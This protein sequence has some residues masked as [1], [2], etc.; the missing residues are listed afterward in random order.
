MDNREFKQGLKMLLKID[1]MLKCK[2][3]KNQV[4]RFS[5]SSINQVMCVIGLIALT[6]TGC[7][8]QAMK[9]PVSSPKAIKLNQVGYYP[10]APKKLVVS[11]SATYESFSIVDRNSN[12]TVFTADLSPQTYRELSG[13][14]VQVGDFTAF[15]K[16]GEY[17]VHIEG[18]GSSYPFEIADHVLLE[19][20]KAS[21]KGLYYQRASMDLEQQYAGNWHRKMGHPDENVRFHP[22]SGSEGELSSPGGWYDAGD[23]GKYV[24]N[25]AFSLGQ[26]LLLYEQYSRTLDNLRLNIPESN[27]EVSDYLDEIKYEMDWLLTMQDADGGVFFKLT[28]KNFE[29]M[30]MPEEAVS[31]RY[32]IGKSTT[33]TLDFAAAAAKCYTNFHK[34]DISYAQRCLAAAVRAW[35]WARQNPEVAYR[36]PEDIS[37]GQYGDR[38]FEQEFYWAAAELYIATGDQQYLSYLT[39]NSPKLSFGPG[40][41]WNGFMEFLGAFALIDRI[42]NVH[43]VDPLKVM[44]LELADELADRFLKGVQWSEEQ[45]K[46][47]EDPYYGGAGYGNN[48][49]PDLSNT[50]FMIDALRAAG[51]DRARVLVAFHE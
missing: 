26:L 35:E 32:I 45:E 16:T 22:S 11:K 18:L 19:A 34:I 15:E 8:S 30:V 44:V 43:L 3:Q 49:R 13:E 36:N 42:D 38:D 2:L 10:H 48:K 41:S 7:Q 21:V 27:N 47:K 50:V 25:G 9:K 23:Y 40:N 28:T 12:E 20:L 24:V 29:G 39:E 51:N 33:A 5:M 14:Q 31:Q 4:A 6:M 46:E 1:N 37:T 17:A